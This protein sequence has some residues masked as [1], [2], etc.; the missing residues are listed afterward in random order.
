MNSLD[1]LKNI[2]RFDI[3]YMQ[4]YQHEWKLGKR[5]IVREKLDVILSGGKFSVLTL[6]YSNKVLSQS[7]FRIHKCYIINKVI[8]SF[9]MTKK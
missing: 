8:I 9:M 5:E 1:N 7:A 4:L 2:F 6:S 3:P